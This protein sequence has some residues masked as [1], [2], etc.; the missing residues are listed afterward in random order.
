MVETNTHTEVAVFGGGCFWCTEA[1]FKMLKG[2][3]RVEPGYSGGV[4]ANPTY[5]Q[6]SSGNTGHAEVVKIVYDPDIVSY[7]DLLT[8]FFGSHDPTTEDRQGN[9]VGTQY[10]SVIF[11]TSETQR[12]EAEAFISDIEGS[13]ESGDSVV[14]EVVPLSV[15][16]EAEEYHKNYFE[17]HPENPYCA[18]IINPKLEKVQKAFAHLLEDVDR[19][20]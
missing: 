4:V 2:V 8:I 1:V 13:A 11:Y 17:N 3:H 20:N 16:Y 9:D 15:F 12:E 5:E 14:T 10:R 6:V 7:R 19:F 18:V